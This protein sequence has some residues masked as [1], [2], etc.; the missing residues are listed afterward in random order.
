M[1]LWRLSARHMSLMLRASIRLFDHHTM[2][3]SIAQVFV[4][5]F[6]PERL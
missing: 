1:R 4:R 2:P 3:A 5:I 6:H